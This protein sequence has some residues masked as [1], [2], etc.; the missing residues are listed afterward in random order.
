MTEALPA[1]IQQ[2][3]FVLPIGLLLAAFFFFA[4]ALGVLFSGAF[5]AVDGATPE[6]QDEAMR[7]WLAAAL[8]AL[9]IA[10]GWLGLRSLTK[11]PATTHS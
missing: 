1:P 2:R 8:A 5:D 4:I 6:P 7:R 11:A 9:G 10:S 3:S